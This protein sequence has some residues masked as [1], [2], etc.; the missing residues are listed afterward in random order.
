[1]TT[2]IR[3]LLDDCVHCGFCLPTC[4]TY[5]L[6]GEEPDSPRGRILLMDLVEKGELA[7]TDT[8]VEHWDRCLGCMACV[9]SCPSG[10]RYDALIEST[11]AK[12]EREY[13]RPRSDRWR[14]SALFAVLPYHRRL[15]PAA[16]ALAL[17]LPAPKIAP[18][19]KLSRIRQQPPVRTPAAAEPRM[20]VAMLLGCV[21]RAFFGD[22]NAATARVLAAYGCEVLA[23]RD[24]GCCGALEL[25][26]GRAPAERRRTALLDRLQALQVDR[27]VVNSAGCGSAL[28]EADHPAAALVRDVHEVLAE[29]GPPRRL[30]RLD[31]RV[32]Y[33]DACHLGHAQGVR[34]EPRAVLQAIPGVQL[35]EVPDADICCGS[36]GVYNLLQPEAAA[37]LGRRKAAAID[38][39]GAD[40]IAAANPGCL[41]QI[42]AYLERRIET[43]HPVQLLDRALR[44]G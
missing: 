10:V 36:A 23:P 40:V 35:L 29:L 8:V 30:G 1:M 19:L 14:R 15:R 26:A 12:V 39:L 44:A 28:K 17:H 25:H 9:T 27:I 20:K 3:P 33:H 22:V 42:T 6:W 7:I 34:A 41:I 24:Q 31:L 32:A 11:R 18:R 21:Q 38:A 37:E 4:P 13:R 16:Y 43:L 2:D 5:Q